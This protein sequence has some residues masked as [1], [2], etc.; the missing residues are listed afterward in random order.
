MDDQPGAG[1]E[2]SKHGWDE[3]GNDSHREEHE[4]D[5]GLVEVSRPAIAEHDVNTVGNTTGGR[6]LARTFDEVSRTLHAER[7]ATAVLGGGHHHPS[8]TA[9]DVEQAIVG[10]GTGEVQQRADERLRRRQKR[11]E[12]VVVALNDAG[13]LHRE[14]RRPDQR[15]RRPERRG[16]IHQTPVAGGRGEHPTETGAP[17][18]APPPQPDDRRHLARR[19]HNQLVGEAAR[20]AFR[21]TGPPLPRLEAVLFEY[22]RCPSS[23]C[24][25][26]HDQLD[27]VVL[28][29]SDDRR[30]VDVAA[31]T[32]KALDDSR[33]FD[34]TRSPDGLAHVE[35]TSCTI[36]IGIIA[37]GIGE[38]ALCC[39]VKPTAVD[40]LDERIDHLEMR[41]P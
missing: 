25:V 12:A 31:G 5:G 33:S 40:R 29:W 18:R 34:L 24:V 7:C 2:L 14:P 27:R 17:G 20:G 38:S 9:A 36:S 35:R 16:K 28:A 37:T 30:S 32:S 22:V 3:V 8:V 23:P 26:G 1:A 6:P 15:I 4:H 39:F 19:G 41:L 11:P 10:A 13:A 21:P